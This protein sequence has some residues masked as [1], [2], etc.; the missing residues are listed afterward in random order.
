MKLLNN[1]LESLS[2]IFKV[3]NKYYKFIF[4]ILIAL[5]QS[6]I[7]LYY[8]NSWELSHK[9]FHDDSYYYFQTAKNFVNFHKM[10]F[11]QLTITNGFHPLWMWILIFVNFFLNLF[12]IKLNTF[13][14]TLAVLVISN[15]LLVLTLIKIFQ[16]KLTHKINTFSKVLISTIIYFI[17]F[18]FFNNGMETGL[19]I[20]LFICFINIIF[21]NYKTNKWNFKLI[22]KLIL[23]TTLL[24]LSRLDSIFFVLLII[25]FE[26]LRKKSKIVF[27]YFICIFLVIV[28][29]TIQKIII[30]T[31]SIIPV[32]TIIKHFWGEMEFQS[33]SNSRTLGISNFMKIFSY[34]KWNFNKAVYMYSDIPLSIYTFFN[35]RYGF[36]S[37]SIFVKPYISYVSIICITMI[38]FN[39]LI[40]VYKKSGFLEMLLLL[41]FIVGSFV[42]LYAS[43]YKNLQ[44]RTF[45]WY[46]GFA[47]VIFSFLLIL[48][49]QKLNWIILVTCIIFLTISQVKFLSSKPSDYAILYK[50]A[51]DFLISAN[52]HSAGTWAAGHIG[53]F[54]NGKVVNLEGLMGDE[55]MFKLNQINKIDDFILKNNLE[56]IIYN[57]KIP[58]TIVNEDDF[59]KQRL[60]PLK[61]LL[62]DYKLVFSKE[63]NS[64]YIF[65]YKKNI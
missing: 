26:I 16:N 58:Q 14:T 25:I 29:L 51:S 65:I 50:N 59:T 35:P 45:N 11:D 27:A 54:S 57:D 32:S 10:T 22:C 38:M 60:I 8:N 48:F 28:A 47:T 4:I 17:M 12:G 19:S 34:L 36:A 2:S 15:I 7:I 1:A 23:I 62:K 64:K 33:F 6:S 41:L 39:S 52:Y 46:L 55:N 20:Y 37:S 24:I 44:A 42:L 13:N 3:S 43:F 9:L 21:N 40:H 18:P 5:F 30:H 49:L 31:N 61:R 56:Y 63:Q 53:Y